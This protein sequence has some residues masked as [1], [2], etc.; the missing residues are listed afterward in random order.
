MALLLYW[1]TLRHLRGGQ[2]VAR[3][4]KRFRRPDLALRV[5]QLRRENLHSVGI[6][7]WRECALDGVARFTF[8]NESRD[9]AEPGDWNKPGVPKLWLYNLHYFD[10]INAL[11]VPG[12]Q[13]SGPATAGHWMLRWIAENPAPVGNG[14]EPYPLSLRMVNWIKWLVKQ[15]ALDAAAE[16]EI[17]RSLELQAHVLSQRLEVDLLGNHLF[18]NAKALVFAGSFFDGEAADAWFQRGASVLSSELGEQ[19]LSDGGYFEL[20]PMY[21]SIVLEGILDL[22]SLQQA[23]PGRPWNERGLGRPAL[24]GIAGSM[25]GWLDAMT[26]PDGQFAL[27]N[28]AAYGIAASPSMLRR[29]AQRL[30]VALPASSTTDGIRTMK[31]SGF[32]R[33]KRGPLVALLDVGNVGPDHIPGHGH[34]DTLTFEWA[35]ANQRVVVD[36]G[37]SL[38]GE[39]AERLRQRGTAAHNTVVVDGENSSEVWKGF[40]VARRARPRDVVV[41]A[42]GENWVVSAAHDGYRRLPGRVMHRRRWEFGRN[43]L[44]VA[45]RVE[46]KFAA[47]QARFHFHPGIV[48]SLEGAHGG[49]LRGANGL[50][51]GIAIRKGRAR[52]EDSTY[53]PEFGRALRNQCLVVELE[54]GESIVSFGY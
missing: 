11:H 20:S 30:G 31:E 49:G 40:R 53:H 2:I 46:G 4:A 35:H 13:R 7:P 39:S 15:P 42:G 21:H 34:A 23:Y 19:I 44:Q 37:T 41:D 48:V 27:F 38:Y 47:A 1:H 29:Y 12:A 8:L 36:S 5:G 14:W 10:W 50:T 45:D 22:I 16:A 6:D 25:L 24:D 18:E 32:V 52:L 17:C 9:F 3:I 51:L 43:T 28:D 54:G 26:H 33:V